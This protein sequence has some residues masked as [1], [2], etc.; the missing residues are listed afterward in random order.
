MT[1]RGGGRARKHASPTPSLLNVAAQPVAAD[2]RMQ[3]HYLGL[4]ASRSR[5]PAPLDSTASGV[6][7]PRL[8][9]ADHRNFQSILPRLAPPR[10][11]P[12]GFGSISRI[13]HSLPTAAS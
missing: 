9:A 8:R 3:P 5:V 2:V 1:F 11:P 6:T 12:V 4:S 7:P 13:P 10:L